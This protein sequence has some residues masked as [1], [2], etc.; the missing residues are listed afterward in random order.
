MDLHWHIN[1]LV[2]VLHVRVLELL[3]NTQPSRW[4]QQHDWN[5]HRFCRQTAPRPQCICSATVGT[6]ASKKNSTV[7]CWTRVLLL[8]EI[9][10]CLHIK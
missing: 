4:P 1:D 10:D 9:I 2:D 5:V 7:H 8:W 3:S 6:G